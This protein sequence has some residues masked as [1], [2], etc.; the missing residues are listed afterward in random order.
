MSIILGFLKIVVILGTLITI[1]ELGHFT[2]A[3]FCKV[4]VNKFSI[5]FGPKILKKQKGETEY[6]LRLFPFGGF[7]QM[8]GEEE[9]SDEERAFNKKPVG[10]RIAIVA[11]GAIVNILF[12]LI[13][14]FC[15]ASSFGIYIGNQVALL[16]EGPLYEAGIRNG[17][18]I[19]S[20]NDDKMLTQVEIEDKIFDSKN[21]EFKFEIERNDELIEFLVTIPYQERGNIGVAFGYSGEIMF[22]LPNGPAEKM[23]L[24]EN[25][26]VLAV[27][28]VEYPEVTG[29]ISAIR[30]TKNKRIELKVKKAE[31]GE[32]II[33]SGDTD[34]KEERIFS[35]ACEVI[36]P[37]FFEGIKYA[38]D[39]TWHFFIATLKGTAEIFTGKVEN[40]EVM[41]PVGIAEEITST[42]NGYDFFYLMAA[43]SLSLGIFNLIPIPALDGGRILIL[44]IEGIRRKPL[45]EKVE[46]AII[47]AGFAV[48]LVLA[49]TIT[50]SD[51]TNI[52]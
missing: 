22:V 26:I 19:I 2:V 43:I 31:T 25:D 1:H 14:Y 34:V 41:G 50:V 27:D 29:V 38:L 39:E 8:E 49:I 20:I 30:N 40:V 46:Q 13:V 7:V 3:K 44:I 4:K 12:S 16:E 24:E 48:I 36:E 28:G 33:V 9:R 15:L 23:G 35:L 10:Q 42:N 17:D 5:G 51:V 37:G 47:L 52:F 6:T 32:T 45:P 18:K 11:A 21:D